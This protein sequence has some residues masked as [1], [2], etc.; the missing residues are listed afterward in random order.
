MI[1]TLIAVS[2]LKDPHLKT[3]CE[4][5]LDRIKSFQPIILKE[6]ASADDLL[7][8]KELILLDEKGAQMTSVEFAKLLQQQQNRGISSLTFAIGDAEGW[9]QTLKE[10]GY[11]T[12]SLSSMTMQHDIARLVFLEQLY[13][14]LS[15]LKGH[16]YHRA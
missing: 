3:I 14:A 2:K 10:K 1:I 4:F 13:R 8:I 11:K 15:L 16:P 12:L 7:Q 9:P 6:I 5:Y